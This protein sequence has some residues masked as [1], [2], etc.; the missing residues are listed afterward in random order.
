MTLAPGEHLGPFEIVSPLGAGG[1]GE[2]FRALD[3]RLGREVAVKVLRNA[4]DPDRLERFQIEARAA[5]SLSHPNVLALY[6]VGTHAG[7]PY[8]VTELLEGQS[9]RQRMDGGSLPLRKAIDYARQIGQGIAAAHDKGIVHRD[10][11]PENVFVTRDGQVKVLDF[12]LAKLT[13]PDPVE[14]GE[15]DT[16]GRVFGTVGY[17]SPEQVRGE[18]VDARS[19]IFSFGS[20]L[21]EMVTGRRAFKGDTAVDTM[22]QILRVDPPPL[23]LDRGAAPAAVERVLW[24][25][26]EKAPDERFQSARDLCFDLQTLEDA[27]VSGPQ[28]TAVGPLA[29]RRLPWAAGILGALLLGAGLHALV[30]KSPS[31]KAPT[32]HRLTFR[33][34]SIETARF[35]PDG[36]T[37]VYGASWDGSPVEL[38]STRRD[39]PEYR[40]LGFRTTELLSISA[41]GEMAISLGRRR[42]GTFVSFGTLARAPLAGGAPREMERDVQE[43]DWSPKGEIAVVRTIGGRNR[44]EF[45]AGKEIFETAGW[46]SHP[47]F[48]PAGDAIAFLDHPVWGDDGGNVAL[49]DL[50]GQA[51]LLS[52]GWDS[53]E[54]LAWHPEGKEV[55]FTGTR[56]GAARTLNAVSLRG[57]ERTVYAM[58]GTLTIDDITRQG[59]VLLTHHILRREML[60]RLAGEEKE[61]DLTWLDY[62]FPAELTS[63]GSALLFAENGEGGGRGYAV[64]SR[65]TDGTAAVRLGE[66]GA[67]ALSPDGKWALATTHATS[68]DQQLVM[69]P[70]G[71]GEAQPVSRSGIQIQAAAWLPDGEHVLLAGNRRGRPVQCFVL[72]LKDGEAKAIA[73]EGTRFALSSRPVTP[74]G[75]SV[76]LR[77][78]E[79]HQALYPLGGGETVPVPGLA[80]ED[81]PVR[82]SGDGR[83]LYVY[84]QGTV[85]VRVDRIDVRRGRREPWRELVP[86]D[87][88]GVRA[89]GPIL[90]TPDGRSYVYGYRRVMAELYLVE[91]LR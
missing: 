39:S 76:V 31:P 2:V 61:R 43:A 91:G 80:P 24:H 50:S 4:A 66:G 77:D 67:L 1:M 74:D 89:I 68:E 19:D 38:F 40:S 83:W 58:A 73:A 55:W 11:K 65:K 81:E 75:R 46:I 22:N 49:V 12:G 59:D 88:A 84:R 23:S 72:D 34:G 82:W 20:I 86:A 32:I 56:Q 41:G 33:R 64:Y 78:P 15:T 69:L 35:T 3:R 45:P 27:L 51:R 18:R 63:D 14:G 47:R 70:T 79:G 57:A 48:S 21:Y 26:L 25:C 13:T 54:G 62:S 10:L 6:D 7:R 5:S 28:V 60:G 8:V 9:L 16:V 85:P 37:I 17:M 90:L 71:V 29:R 30:S 52:R 87:A 44:L 42:V 53:L 36:Q